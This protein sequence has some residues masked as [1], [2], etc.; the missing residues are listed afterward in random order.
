MSALR[1]LVE[2]P[3][4]QAPMAGISLADMVSAVSGA[5]GL[6]SLGS[7]TLPLE[8]IEAQVR[9]VRAG[10]GATRPFAVNFFC[11][12]PPKLDEERARAMDRRL[13]PYRRELG[14]PEETGPHPAP[15]PPFGPQALELV[16]SLSPPVVSFHF[17]LPEP[18]ALTAIQD[19]GIVVLSTA[20]TVAEARILED[21][22][23]DAIVAQGFEAGGHRGT[24]ASDFADA[25]IGTLALV[26]QIVAAVSV[27]VIAAGGIV[28][29]RGIAA[30]LLLGAA[31]AQLGTAFLGCPEAQLDPL[32]RR[33]LSD[34]A[35]AARTRVTTLFSG[36]PARALVN[37][38]VEEL[39]DLEGKT[40]DFPLQRFHTAPLGAA[41]AA[42]G[43][44]D[45]NAMWAGQSAARLRAMPAAELCRTLA[46]ETSEALEHSP[47]R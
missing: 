31:A 3:I 42:R 44:A 43:S 27:P 10:G 29:G 30:A 32:Y 37:R 14:L 9:V 39:A 2:V 34:P 7:S 23:V 26:P 5:G 40:P 6:G 18:R 13:A 15:P 4:V 20:T 11:H 19:A 21:R 24:F 16:L 8:T 1:G 47:R 22:G 12:T 35:A 45:F 41:A 17:G 38:L 28:D 33:T 36:R 25:Q 46:R